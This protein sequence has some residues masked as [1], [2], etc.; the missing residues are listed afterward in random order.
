MG[1]DISLGAGTANEELLRPFIGA[2]V[3]RGPD[4]KWEE[5]DGGEGHLGTVRKVKDFEEIMVVWDKGIIANYRCHGA[6]DLKIL[7]SGPAG[8]FLA[9]Y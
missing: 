6:Y 5:Q 1:Q 9:Q 3:V 7:D 4:W 2:R 8:L